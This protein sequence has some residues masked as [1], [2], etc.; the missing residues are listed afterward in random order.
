MNGGLENIGNTCAIN[1]LIQ[2]IYSL[3]SLRSILL[4]QNINS[5]ISSQL[6]DIFSK[7]AEGHSI[8]P[9]GFVRK[10][11]EIFEGFLIPGEQFDI[12]ELW[13]LLA[14]K[15][16]DELNTTTHINPSNE[17]EEKIIK[18]NNNKSSEWQRSIQGVNISI[19]NCNS[20]NENVIN[21][22]LFTVLTLDLNANIEICEMILSFFK[23]EDLTEWTCDKCK[24]K[25]GKKQ[26]KIY[27]LPNVLCIL[28]KR[29]NNNFQKLENPINI[30]LDLNFQTDTG[31]SYYKLKGIGNHFG[32]FNMGHYTS[33]VCSNDRWKYI[34]D[35]NIQNIDSDTFSQNNKYAYILFYER[36]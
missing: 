33:I 23:I 25:G 4:K 16:S 35:L 10:L 6:Y 7:F 21:T 3:D 26:Y 12:G 5:S 18:M 22:D 24:N 1:S 14:D 11:I 13:I 28:I 31:H 8:S 30:P 34:D 19:T 27:K 20:C 2:C 32:S 15:I 17:I 29:F 36:A 9:N